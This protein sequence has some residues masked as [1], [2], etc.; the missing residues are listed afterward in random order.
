MEPLEWAGL[1]AAIVV[2]SAAAIF[3]FFFTPKD[4]VGQVSSQTMDGAST[5]LA[6]YRTER[7]ADQ[8]EMRKLKENVEALTARVDVLEREGR[9]KDAKIEALERELSEKDT[10][11]LRLEGRIKT[12]LGWIGALVEQVSKHG[13]TPA[14]WEEMSQE[15][16]GDDED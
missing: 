10:L 5:L 1:I 16:F 9:R 13:E 3:V 4:K 6:E 12:L 11:I 15:L 8:E 7:E 14:L 2:P